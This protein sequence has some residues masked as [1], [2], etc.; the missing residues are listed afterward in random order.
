MDE[1]VVIAR[2]RQEALDQAAR[3]LGVRPP[4]PSA[5]AGPEGSIHG[6]VDLG[7]GRACKRRARIEGGRGGFWSAVPDPGLATNRL[8]GSSEP[9]AYTSCVHLDLMREP[10]V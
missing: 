4:M 7:V 5:K 6:R 8:P 1:S 9:G 2:R 10:V 3:I